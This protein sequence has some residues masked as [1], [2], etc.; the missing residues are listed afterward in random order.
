VPC[1][2]HGH[3]DSCHYDRNVE[4]QGLSVNVDGLYQGGG[5]CD[6]CKVSSLDY[7]NHV[8]MVIFRCLR[9]E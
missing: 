6:N 1:Q 7:M 3:A 2:C 9:V 4:A 5:V 8:K